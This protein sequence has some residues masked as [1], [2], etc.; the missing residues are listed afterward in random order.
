MN[1]FSKI[2][3]LFKPATHRISKKFPYTHVFKVSSISKSPILFLI[4]NPIE[5]YRLVHWGDEKEYVLSMI[6]CV[7]EDD[8]FLDIGSSVGLIS[9][10]AALKASKGKV[11]SIE[12]DP[13]NFVCLNINYGLN[14]ITDNIALQLAVGY[15]KSSME[16]YSRGSNDLSPSLRKVNGINETINIQ[17]ESVDDLIKS[18]TIPFPTIIKIDIE[19]AEMMALQGMKELLNSESKPRIIFIE[20]HPN[21]LESFNTSES[22][23]KD[24][25]ANLDYKIIDYTQRDDQILCKLEL[26]D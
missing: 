9:I 21:F 11:V 19:G 24:F 10:L 16:L 25:L 17:V 1:I 7:R 8:V 4:N 6:D 2:K 14:N 22:E 3:G 13:E 26:I 15:E 18:G 20:I 12:P 23:V 5:E